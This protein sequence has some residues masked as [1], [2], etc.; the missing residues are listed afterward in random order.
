MTSVF[1]KL[2]GTAAVFVMG[3]M[4]QVAPV[5]RDGMTWSSEELHLN[6]LPATYT[7]KPSMANALALEGLEEYDVPEHGDLRRVASLDTDFVYLEPIK[8][9]VQILVA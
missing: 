3:D 5:E 8:G 7:Q 1:K 6:S 9:W 4:D 2:A